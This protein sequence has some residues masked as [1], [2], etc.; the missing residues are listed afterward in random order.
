MV[1][2]DLENLTKLQWPVTRGLCPQWPVLSVLCPSSLGT[3]MILRRGLRSPINHYSQQSEARGQRASDQRP[4]SPGVPRARAQNPSDTD[5][6]WD[7]SV[8]QDATNTTINP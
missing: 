4:M 8:K 3:L 6:V 1:L 2:R 5:R 7:G